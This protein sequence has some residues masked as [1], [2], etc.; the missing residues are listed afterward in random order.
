MGWYSGSYSLY[1]AEHTQPK[2]QFNIEPMLAECWML[3]G[4]WILGFNIEQMLDECWRWLMLGIDICSTLVEH[5]DKWLE[6]VN[7]EPIL[8]EYEQISNVWN[9]LDDKT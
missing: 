8:N 9:V 2:Q 1:E 4:C 3:P 5:W 7:V 6:F